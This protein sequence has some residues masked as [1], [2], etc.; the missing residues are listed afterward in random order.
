[1]DEMGHSVP[2]GKKMGYLGGDSRGEAWE[3]ACKVTVLQKSSELAIQPSTPQPGP[4]TAETSQIP[5]VI[6]AEVGD[7]E[8]SPVPEEMNKVELILQ[9]LGRGVVQEETLTRLTEA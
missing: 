5:S 1:M 4:P 9:D 7:D 2:A 6:I 3:R 8:G